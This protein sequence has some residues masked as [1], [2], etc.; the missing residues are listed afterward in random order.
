MIQPPLLVFKLQLLLSVKMHYIN[1]SDI[2]QF[3]SVI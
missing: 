2:S 1:M 3:F